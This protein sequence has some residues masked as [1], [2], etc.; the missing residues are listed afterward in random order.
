MSVIVYTR[1]VVSPTKDFDVK[2]YGQP[3][4]AVEEL[5]EHHYAD[6]V[7]YGI[8]PSGLLHILAEVPPAPDLSV[9]EGGEIKPPATRGPDDPTERSIAVYGPGQ[10]AFAEVND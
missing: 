8:D 9:V 5:R 6:A 7:N 10:W 3:R 4:V 2:L 1:H